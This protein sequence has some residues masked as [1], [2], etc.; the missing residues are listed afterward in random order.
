MNWRQ[1][2]SR[3]R[4]A[5]GWRC[6]VFL[7]TGVLPSVVTQN[8]SLPVCR[9]LH[10]FL[11]RSGP[12]ISSLPF[13][14]KPLI[15]PP[16]SA[17]FLPWKARRIR[18]EKNVSH[19]VTKGAKNT[20]D[21]FFCVSLCL[22]VFVRNSSIFSHLPGE[23]AR[24]VVSGPLPAGCITVSGFL[25]RARRFFLLVTRHSRR[26]FSQGMLATE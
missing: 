2:N 11:V 9:Q 20:K 15:R 18:K 4:H 3:Y 13:G 24:L 23:K 10:A 7:G 8:E 16:P 26:W 5:L 1:V 21:L 22:G 14:K 19:K 6:H 12:S 25:C 17:T